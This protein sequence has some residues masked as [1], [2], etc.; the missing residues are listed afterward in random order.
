MS[1]TPLVPRARRPDIV[2]FSHLRWRSVYQRPHHLMSRAARGGRVFWVEEPEVGPAPGISIE[3]VSDELTLVV[4]TI[5]DGPPNSG[6]ETIGRL[7]REV[8]AAERVDTPILWYY[9][10]TPR[11]R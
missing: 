8:L 2:V 11:T 10:T 4:P 9:A 5:S 1:I 6:A 3:H 7:L